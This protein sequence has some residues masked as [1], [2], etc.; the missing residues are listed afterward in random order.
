MDERCYSVLRHMKLK[1]VT[2]ISLEEFEDE[3]LLEIKK[4]RARAE[5]C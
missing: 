2:V 5:Y 1:N 4:K 3:E